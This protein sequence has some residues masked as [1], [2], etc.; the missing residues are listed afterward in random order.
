MSWNF[1]MNRLFCQDKPFFV[2]DKK[3]SVLDEFVNI[4][5]IFGDIYTDVINWTHL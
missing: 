1:A 5:H 4:L 2:T 3:W